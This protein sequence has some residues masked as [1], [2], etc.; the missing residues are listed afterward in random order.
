MKSAMAVSS[1]PLFEAASRGKK[2]RSLHSELRGFSEFERAT[3]ASTHVHHSHKVPVYE[4]EF[5]TAK[6]RAGHS[7]HEISY[8]ACYKP[9]L[10][11]FFISRFCDPGD[12]VYDP[13]MGRGTTLIEAQIHGCRAWG[14]DINPLSK[15]LVLPRL[16][17]P[18]LAS[19]KERLDLIELPDVT[20]DDEDLLVFFEEKTLREICG[21]QTYFGQRHQQKSFDVLDGWIQMVACNRLTGHSNG[22]F[23]VYTLPPNQATSVIAQ[24]KINTKR[25][26]VPEYRNTKALIWKKSRQLLKDPLPAGFS[27]NDATVLCGSADHSPGLP[28]KSVKLIVTS[29]PFVDTVDYLGDNWMRMWFTGLELKKDSLWQLRS[30]KD[31]TARMTDTFTEFHRVLRTDGLI[32][33]EVGEVRGGVLLLEH[34]VIEAATATGLVPECV[35]INSQVFT[36]TANCWGVDN[37]KK[38]TNSNRIV[39]LRKDGDA[40]RRTHPNKIPSCLIPTKS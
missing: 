12:V 17:P 15:V 38:G 23:S 24:R 28:D 1:L 8:R 4:N 3:T 31:W 34:A 25:N 11:A 21:W 10:P 20:P 16:S 5:W 14:A 2:T 36:K 29:P 27:R 18:S 30:V 37:N 32:A 26:Q 33:F 19:I 35:M 6:Q 40:P 13:F 7:I 9:Q 39:V 22:F